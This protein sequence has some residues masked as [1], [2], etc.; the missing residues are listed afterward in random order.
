VELLTKHL[1]S[2]RL[3]KASCRIDHKLKR[4]EH[5]RERHRLWRRQTDCRNTLNRRAMHACGLVPKLPVNSTGCRIRQ[6]SRS[7]RHNQGGSNEGFHILCAWRNSFRRIAGVSVWPHRP[8]Q[9]RQLQRSRFTFSIAVLLQKYYWKD[10]QFFP[11]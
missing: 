10:Y 8:G 6:R 2:L 7:G 5:H 3:I 1:L 4:A 11:W 9:R